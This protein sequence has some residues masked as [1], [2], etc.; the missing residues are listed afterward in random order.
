[1][2][3]AVSLFAFTLDNVSESTCI[4]DN[5]GNIVFLNQAGK[6]LLGK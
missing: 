6:L 1:M 2:K 4:T 3:D 5:E